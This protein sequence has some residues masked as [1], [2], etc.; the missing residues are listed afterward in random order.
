MNL[1]IFLMDFSVYYH[2]HIIKLNFLNMRNLHLIFKS[3]LL[4]HR[5]KTLIYFEEFRKSNFFRLIYIEATKLDKL[6][7]WNLQ[8]NNRTLKTFLKLKQSSNISK[9][10]NKL[11]MNQN[12]YH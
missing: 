10:N 9:A 4:I 11:L 6:C 3:N 1:Q 8:T 12:R 5:S 2:A 7:H